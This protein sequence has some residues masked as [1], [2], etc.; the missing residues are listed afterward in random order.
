MTND[1][2]N[3]VRQQLQQEHSELRQLLGDIHRILA[4]RL[5]TVVHVSEQ[6]AALNEHV[7]THFN[8][9]EV[10]GFFDQ[11][12]GK[13]SASHRVNSLRDEHQRLLQAVRRINEHAKSGNGSADWWKRLESEF[14]EFNKDF[15]E[16]EHK[17]NQLL[18]D[19]YEQDIGAAD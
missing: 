5:D 12:L 1:S 3:D 7:Q 9:E 11:V 18:Q 10:G 6:L 14:H 2:E 19:A 17:E 16:H 8:D 13:T 15:M 4:E